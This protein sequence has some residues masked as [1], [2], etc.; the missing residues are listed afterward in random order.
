M[1]KPRK[2]QI[3]ARLDDD[4][5]EALKRLAAAAGL[6]VG[7]LC[8]QI[9]VEYVLVRQQSASGGFDQ[10]SHQFDERLAEHDRR[11]MREIEAVIKPLKKELTVIKAQIDSLLESVAPA[12][13]DEYRKNVEKLIQAAGIQTN[14]VGR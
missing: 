2:N 4:T 12:R 13:R 3:N 7:G 10:V 8:S 9:L 1:T 14:G 6:P 5:D 11:L